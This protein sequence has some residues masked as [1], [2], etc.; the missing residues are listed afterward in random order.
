MSG[1]VLDIPLFPLHTVLFPGG[2][3]PLRIFEPRY[4]DMVTACLREQTPFGVVLIRTGHETG[5]AADPFETG[6]LAAIVDF[7]ESATGL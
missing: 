3:L 1:T 4:I 7:D 6:T 2:F 5:A